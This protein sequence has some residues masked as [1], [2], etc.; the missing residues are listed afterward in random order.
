MQSLHRIDSPPA[1]MPQSHAAPRRRRSLLSHGMPQSGTRLSLCRR[2]A[3]TTPL[4]R[5]VENGVDLTP[6]RLSD[7]RMP[8]AAESE[9]Q[10]FHAALGGSVTGLPGSDF[11]SAMSGISATSVFSSTVSIYQSLFTHT[12]EDA[13]IACSDFI[14]ESSGKADDVPSQFYLPAEPEA[15]GA[16]EEAAAA[17]SAKTAVLTETD[18]FF[19]LSRPSV[20]CVADSPLGEAVRRDNELYEY[21]T[22]GKGR[23]RKRSSMEMQTVSMMRKTAVALTARLFRNNS[24]D[25]ASVWDIYDTY[26]TML[27]R[28]AARTG[29]LTTILR[30]K[31][32]DVSL[33]QSNASLPMSESQRLEPEDQLASIVKTDAF[34]DA[35]SQVERILDSN[36]YDFEQKVFKELMQADPLRMEVE[37]KYG[38]HLLW[39][40]TC[41]EV[42]GKSVTAMCWNAADCNLVAVGY[43]KFLYSDETAGAVAVWS[44]K[45]PTR[46]ERLYEMGPAVTALAFSERR[47]NLLAVGRYDGG[48]LL[49]DTTARHGR[50]LASADR[51]VAG[52]F[53]PVWQLAWF[54]EYLVATTQDGRVHKYTGIRDFT[55]LPMMRLARVEGV[56]K[57]LSQARKCW[58]EETP[59]SCHPAAL[60]LVRQPRNPDAYDVA[61]DEGCVHHCSAHHLHNHLDVF[62]AHRAPVYAMQYNPFCDKVFLTAGGDRCVRVWARGVWQPVATLRAGRDAVRAAAWSP[63]LAPLLAAAADVRLQ[64]WDLARAA[65]RPASETPLPGAA[66]CSR[67]LFTPSGSALLAA[68]DAGAVH[69]FALRDVPHPPFFQAAALADAIR[70]LNV[71]RPELLVRLRKL[72]SPF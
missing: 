6:G 19:L 58:P 67:L 40:F 31:T 23:M 44:V 39:T 57:G 42:K 1:S 34:Q 61:S 2:P 47:P 25:F 49:L 11:L 50:P 63:A 43:G 51:L 7:A 17:E 55:C 46:P 59:Y 72:G 30:D 38:L 3:Q 45:N 54:A 36:F 35:C 8:P 48:V 24:C 15:R 69:V 70:R 66:A 52:S 12:I 9:L 28:P 14:A 68:D 71:T 53:S 5:L 13:S 37:F 56:L 16:I 18:T 41:P 29:G 62:Q 60:V 20:S 64:L 65:F 27:K 4:P 10:V 26:A 22:Q 33:P 21:L 32:S